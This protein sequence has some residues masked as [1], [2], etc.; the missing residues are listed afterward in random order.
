MTEFYSLKELV[1]EVRDEQ[2]ETTLIQT[3]ILTTLENIDNHLEKL[4]SKVASHEKEIK[5]LGTEHVKAKAV[6]STLSIVLTTV[7]AG[8]TFLFK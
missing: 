5:D 6:F 7:W 4:N 1:G 8:V 3:S 2:R